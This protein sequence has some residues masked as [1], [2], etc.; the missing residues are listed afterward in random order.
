MSEKQPMQADGGGTK[1]S[2]D[3]PEIASRKGGAGESGGGAYPNPYTGKEKKGNF[4]GFLGHGGQTHIAYEG[5]D[6]PNATTKGD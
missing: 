2:G 3:E 1:R 5:P 6:N 4:G